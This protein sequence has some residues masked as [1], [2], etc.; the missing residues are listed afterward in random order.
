MYLHAD[1]TLQSSLD[2]ISPNKLSNTFIQRGGIQI[3]L[4]ANDAYVKKG[5]TTS[6]LRAL[7]SIWMTIFLFPYLQKEMEEKEST[8]LLDKNHYISIF[9]SS[10]KTMNMLKNDNTGVSRNGEA[11]QPDG[12]DNACD[13]LQVSEY[14]FRTLKFLIKLK[15]ITVNDITGKNYF[16]GYVGFLMK[17][18]ERIKS[19]DFGVWFEATGFFISCFEQNILSKETKSDVKVL[20]P[21]CVECIK[22]C[23][24]CN[25][26]Y[27]Y[28]FFHS[29]CP[30]R[31]LRKVSKIIRRKTIRATPGLMTTLGTLVDS[32]TTDVDQHTKDYIY[33]CLSYLCTPPRP[34]TQNNV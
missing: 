29:A 18:P 34:A 12:G 5:K 24:G 28:Y 32:N 23:L 6:Q 2:D 20:L 16:E 10:I 31:L 22:K 30:I 1:D 4:L 27:N 8:G 13:S 14:I 3:L 15:G 33:R 21:F 11:T 7:K 19:N 25:K 17:D 26:K 9:E